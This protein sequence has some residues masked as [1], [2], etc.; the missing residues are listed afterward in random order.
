MLDSYFSTLYMSISYEILLL[1]DDVKN[2]RK[3][4]DFCNCGLFILRTLD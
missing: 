1:L 2:V 3:I 4:P